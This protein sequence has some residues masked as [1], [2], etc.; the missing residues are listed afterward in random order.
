[1]NYL[2]EDELVFMGIDGRWWRAFQG[3]GEPVEMLIRGQRLRAMPRLFSMI[4][5]TLP[6]CLPV[7]AQSAE[8][9]A[10]VAER[11]IGGDY[12]ATGLNIS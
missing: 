7:Y 2:R 12:P 6:M 4:L 1:M 9:V 3:S 11:Q 10:G 8:L 5:S